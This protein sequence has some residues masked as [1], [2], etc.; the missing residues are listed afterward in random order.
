VSLAAAASG[1]APCPPRQ[2]A[3]LLAGRPG[4]RRPLPCVTAAGC[5]GKAEES[6]GREE[7]AS[8]CGTSPAAAA[9][10]SCL[11]T[12]ATKGRCA[13]PSR[14][15][16]MLDEQ[17]PAA[18]ALASAGCPA[19]A[20]LI[21][22]AHTGEGG[23]VLVRCCLLQQKARAAGRSAGCWVTAPVSPGCRCAGHKAPCRGGTGIGAAALAREE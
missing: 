5:Q 14:Q 6:D 7:A 4:G 23:E 2:R 18:T 22:Q 16:Q 21:L 8:R 9:A 19:G 3:T 10:S 12:P 11:R 1:W 13:Q 17:V 15:P 20:L